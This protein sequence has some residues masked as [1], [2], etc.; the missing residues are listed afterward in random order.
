MNGTAVNIYK[1]CDDFG[2]SRLMLK[3]PDVCRTHQMFINMKK[4]AKT[5]MI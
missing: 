4:M 3:L 1:C 2:I 5:Q